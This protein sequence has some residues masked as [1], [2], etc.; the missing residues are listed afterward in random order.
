M[1]GADM[2]ASESASGASTPELSSVTRVTVEEKNTVGAMV[3][4][5]PYVAATPYLVGMAEM[6][7]SRLVK[8]MLE[9]GQVTVGSRVVIDHLG[10]SKVGAELVIKAALLQRERN[11]F[12]FS[13]TIEDGPRTVA[14]VEHER[15][16]VSLEKMMRA[17]G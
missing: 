13:V 16:A 9:P 17:L 10:P 3:P 11:R 5:M 14:K 15:A 2:T 1:D 6:A 4:G 8:D 7:C 12:K